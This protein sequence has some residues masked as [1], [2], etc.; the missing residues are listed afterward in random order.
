M[1]R[2]YSFQS[3]LEKFTYNS[4][5]GKN[6]ELDCA[7]NVNKIKIIIITAIYDYSL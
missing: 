4:P 6:Q 1:K 3:F 7:E 2:K 5:P